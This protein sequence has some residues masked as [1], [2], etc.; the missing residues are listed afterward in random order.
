M[1]AFGFAY[2]LPSF[3]W[4]RKQA[5][6]I[7]ILFLVISQ[8][9]VYFKFF[10]RASLKLIPKPN[11]ASF[12]TQNWTEGLPTTATA[13]R[14][15]T[16]NLNLHV[17]LETC[18]K[19]LSILCNFPMF[20]KAPDGRVFINKTIIDANENELKDAEGFR[21][22]GFIAPTESGLY[23]FMVTFCSAEI[24]LSPD[25]TSTSATR[26]FSDEKISRGKTED[27]R[28][29][30]EVNLTAGMKYY[31]EVVAT[32]F[33]KTNNP[34]VLWKTPK[35]STFE[36]INGTFLS[37]YHNESGLKHLKIYDELLPDSPACASRM[38]QKTYF[39]NQRD[40]S[41]LSHD[42]VQ[43]IL[44]YCEYSPSYIVSHKVPRYHAVTYHVVHTFI[45]PF[46]KHPNLRDQKNWIFP[47]D[48][49]EA[50]HTVGIFMESL[51]KTNPGYV[52]SWATTL[53][54]IAFELCNRCKR[55]N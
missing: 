25:E 21:M 6:T 22:F 41:Y 5:V 33:H 35:N 10:N 23:V 9:I 45:Y 30:R 43:D 49:K 28:V 44:P 50:L 37:R 11:A 17:W 53:S 39:E 47:L 55:P 34:Q 18:A 8:V 40:I 7:G 4:K 42:E 52:L 16:G 46:P 14:K 51:E 36:V 1:R 31:I 27:S 38:H 13:L 32:C 20:P 26:I 3:F 19:D 29:S 24:W 2:L 12:K 48:E 54:N 15:T